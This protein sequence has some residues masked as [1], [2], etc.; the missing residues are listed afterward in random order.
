M[1][2]TKTCKTSGS[3]KRNEAGEPVFD[4]Q[5]SYTY[6]D[7]LKFDIEEMVEI[8]RGKI[9]RMGPAPKIKHQQINGNVFT[10][11]H[12]ALKGQHCKV[13]LTPADVVLPIENKKKE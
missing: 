10:I 8:I 5:R 2:K 7:Y 4:Y 6:G 11:I 3:I 1:A 12:S 9:F 13:Y